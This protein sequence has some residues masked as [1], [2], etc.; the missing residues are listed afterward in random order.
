MKLI[1]FLMKLV[2]NSV[3]I[4]LKNGTIIQGTIVN[5]DIS[6][7]TYLKNVKMSVKHRNPVSLSQIT[8]RG[9]T[10][11]YFILPDSLPLDA[12]LIDDTPKQNPPRVNP[13]SGMKFGSRSGPSSAGGGGYDHR[14][15]GSF[16]HR[17]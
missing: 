5:V 17:R 6:M 14:S 15:R 16:N 1:R 13:I 11:R 2:N 3:V 10:I 4:E 9:N 8:V 7:N 12:L